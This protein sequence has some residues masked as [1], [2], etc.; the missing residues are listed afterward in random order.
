MRFLSNRVIARLGVL[1]VVLSCASFGCAKRLFNAEA[2]QSVRLETNAAERTCV[3]PTDGDFEIDT[4]KTAQRAI[5]LDRIQKQPMLE[6]AMRKLG[7]PRASASA[8]MLRAATPLYMGCASFQKSDIVR[9]GEKEFEEFASLVVRSYIEN[10]I[11]PHAGMPIKGVA[12]GDILAFPDVTML[13]RFNV[14]II[15][16]ND[17][18]M[19]RSK[20]SDTIH[21][22]PLTDSELA[23][24]EKIRHEGFI[25]VVERQEPFENAYGNV[26]SGKFLSYPPGDQVARLLE[27]WQKAGLVVAKEKDETVFI[28]GV[29]KQLRTCISI[30][31]FAD[32]NGRS[33]TL[34]AVHALAQRGI[35]HSLVWAGEDVLLGETEWV[36][37]F[38]KG[39]Q[40]HRQL[41][42]AL[43][44]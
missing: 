33:C 43:K 34:W 5:V 15:K 44:K 10:E 37:R 35:P 40:V 19:F 23:A 16:S 12:F 13:R 38:A 42:E 24:L 32:G 27:A 17:L 2:Q 30:H 11:K 22:K 39:V 8:W 4:G 29:A 20:G 21:S 3:H 36:A 25:S 18:G 14:E 41:I 1:A 9:Y 26:V 31:P 6:V 28:E 7:V